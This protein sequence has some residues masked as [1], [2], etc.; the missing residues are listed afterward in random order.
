MF[1]RSILY[2]FL[3][4]ISL[5]FLVAPGMS[6]VAFAQGANDSIEEI[7]TTGTRRAQRTASDSVV[8]IDVIAATSLKIWAPRTS[9]TCCE[10]HCRPTTCNVMQSTTR[11][12][13]YVPRR[14]VACHRTTI[15]SWS[16][17]NAAIALAL[18]R[19]SADHSPLVRRGPI[20]HRYLRCRSSRSKSC[21]MALPLITVRMLSQA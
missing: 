15:L 18:L 12:R 5:S 9:T 11:Q 14:C 19:N 2:R 17:V 3:I 1:R 13:W 8:P 16:T 6:P 21:V 7:I 4:P 20:F 10:I